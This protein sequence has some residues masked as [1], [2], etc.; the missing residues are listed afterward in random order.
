MEV[1][2]QLIEKLGNLARLDIKPGEKEALRNDMQQM[3]GFI[4][5]LNELDTA[6]IEPLIHLTEEINVLR[7]DEIKGS[8]NREEA[9][10]NAAL[11]NDSFFM[12][13]KVIKK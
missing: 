6:G 2:P 4:E 1:T 3:I 9:L 7:E 13:P 8:V 11:K 5:K 10:S 12:V